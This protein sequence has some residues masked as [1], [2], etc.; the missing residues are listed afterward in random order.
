MRNEWKSICGQFDRRRH[1]CH[2]LWQTA[3]EVIFSLPSF[4]MERRRKKIC[5]KNGRGRSE[6]KQ[7]ITLPLIYCRLSQLD[8][9]FVSAPQCVRCIRPRRRKN[10]TLRVRCVAYSGCIRSGQVHSLGC[11]AFGLSACHLSLQH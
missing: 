8:G 3:Y 9:F 6:K 11:G 10:D 7:S 1:R 2:F 4:A 5:D